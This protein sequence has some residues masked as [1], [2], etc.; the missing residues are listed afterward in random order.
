M[1]IIIVKKGCH[2]CREA[3][4]IVNRINL[5]LPLNRRINV[6]DNFQQEEF[7]M[8]MHPITEKF[9][10][11][12]YPFLYLDGIVYGNAERDVLKTVLESFFKEEFII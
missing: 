7:G 9:K 2:F 12:G 3:I 10:F 4:I 5:K 6:V 1:R 11:D 8:V